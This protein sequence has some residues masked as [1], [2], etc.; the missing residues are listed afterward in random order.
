MNLK[1]FGWAHLSDMGEVLIQGDAE[2]PCGPGEPNFVAGDPEKEI[3][4]GWDEFGWRH[5]GRKL[6]SEPRQLVRL[7]DCSVLRSSLSRD[8]WHII[9]PSGEVCGIE[10]YHDGRWISQHIRES[11]RMLAGDGITVDVNLMDAAPIEATVDEPTMLVGHFWDHNFCHAL[12]ETASRF[13]VY[14]SAWRLEHLPV[15]WE[16]K[17]PWMREIADIHCPGRAVSMPA[18]HVRYRTLFVPSF[19]A[20]LS[21]PSKEAIGWLRRRYKA[22]ETT[23]ARRIYLSR[24]DAESR[25]VK[26][27]SDLL[28]LLG[29]LGFEPT[30]LTGMSVAEQHRLFRE[31]GVVVAPHG[32]GLSN[33][34][35]AGADVKLIELVPRTYQHHA[36]HYLATWSG[37]WYGR[38]VLDCDERQDMTV[39][40]DMLQSALRAALG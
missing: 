37:Q 33:L 19:Y 28:A 29:P 7:E 30:T 3:E 6:V 13:W 26:N 27:E 12:F 38:L 22:S 39:D 9:G 2:D 15:L 31:V 21:P 24:S 8:R 17:N 36:F 10:S 1:A 40:L 5:A 11:G 35:V 4:D 18:N 34:I 25:R 20:Q 23:G 16:L 32:A 14:D